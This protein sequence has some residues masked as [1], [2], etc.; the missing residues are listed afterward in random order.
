MGTGGRLDLSLVEE[1]ATLDRETGLV[2][3][4]SSLLDDLHDYTLTFR[5]PLIAR[6]L[7]AFTDPANAVFPVQTFWP[8]I[9]NLVGGH[10][11]DIWLA[12][13]VSFDVL[14]TDR[15]DP[16]GRIKDALDTFSRM[17]ERIAG[18]NKTILHHWA[19]ALYHLGL[20]K[21]GEEGDVFIHQAISKLERALE[22]PPTPGQGE[23]PSHLLNTLGTLYAGLHRRRTARGIEAAALWD[24]A[25]KAFE[26]SLARSADNFEALLAYGS[27]LASRA[28][29]IAPSDFG[30]ASDL[31]A[32]ALVYFQ[33]AEDLAGD[34][35]ELSEENRYFILRH[36]N[37][38]WSILDPATAED[39]IEELIRAGNEAGFVLRAYK[40]LRPYDLTDPS[41]VSRQA[42][43]EAV[44]ILSQRNLS[45]EMR[46]P[47]DDISVSPPLFP[48]GLVA[49]G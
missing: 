7:I 46:Q 31:C 44:S 9:E 24:A 34:P 29:E 47:S 17:P 43:E 14:R 35:G 18:F 39:E 16:E 30:S 10:E 5:H 41:S 11:A 28:Q 42:L 23:H 49:A 4:S 33:Q 36:R 26:G 40:L 3:W 48:P 38:I 6:R 1:L 13:R 15:N 25:C 45:I 32:R 27:R 37:Q 2:R 12:E 22:L 19:R 20:G 8:V 21:E